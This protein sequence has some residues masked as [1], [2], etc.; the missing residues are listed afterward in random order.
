[1]KVYLVRK[2]EGEYE[3]YE[4]KTLK[5][6]V[7]KEKAKEF[8]KNKKQLEKRKFDNFYK[9]KGKCYKCP[10]NSNCTEKELE[11]IKEPKPKCYNKIKYVPTPFYGMVSMFSPYCHGKKAFDDEDEF[12]CKNKK[13]PD[14][15]DKITYFMEEYEVE[16]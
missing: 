9:G 7:D 16:E 4:E 13:F 11:N 14:K 15:P 2:A 5:V 12:Y 10:Y 6:F 1:M 3:W 8:L